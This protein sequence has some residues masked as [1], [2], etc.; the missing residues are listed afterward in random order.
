MYAFVQHIS[1]FLWQRGVATCNLSEKL[2]ETTFRW[3][4]L[5]FGNRR[6]IVLPPHLPFQFLKHAWTNILSLM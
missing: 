6:C 2:C 4:A 3:P 5:W 1:W